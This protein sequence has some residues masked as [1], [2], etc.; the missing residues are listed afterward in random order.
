MPCS[1]RRRRG[2]QS[3]PRGAC[4]WWGPGGLAAA[5]QRRA[6][7]SGVGGREAGEERVLTNGVRRHSTGR[8][9][10]TVFETFQIDSIQFKLIQTNF[11]LFKLNWS[12]RDLPRPANFEIKY[13]FEGFDETDNFSY[14]NSFKFGVDFE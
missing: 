1:S 2:V 14:R 6:W 5:R 12:K 3:G 13:G 8:A 7:S 4:R 11:K 9:G 10:Q